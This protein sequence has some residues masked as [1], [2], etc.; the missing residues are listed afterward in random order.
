MRILFIRHGEPDYEHDTLTERGWREAELLSEQIESL[1][2]GEIYVSPLGR[3][4]DTASCTLKKLGREE[5]ILPWLE[6]FAARV[7]PNLSEEVRQAYATELKMVDGRYKPRIVWDILP[8]YWTE[9]AEYYHPEDWRNSEIARCSDMVEQYDKVCAGL[10]ALL[11]EHGYVRE[12]RHYHVE[13]SSSDTIT[14]FCHFGITAV[15]LS[16][17]WSCSPFI[18]LQ[19][20]VTAPSSVTEIFTE[21]RQQGIADFRLTR[22]G[23]VF[24]LTS[25]GE[26]PSFHARFCERYENTEERH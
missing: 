12:G 20:T 23:D 24:H 9:H 3:A 14:F 22:L 11:A 2:P 17:L 8:S 4:R 25:A 6:E 26:K 19:H 7:D 15:M 18:T 5:I 16:H 13:K 21:E 1:S 10:D